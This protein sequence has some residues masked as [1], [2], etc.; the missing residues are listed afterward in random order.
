MLSKSLLL[1]KSKSMLIEYGDEEVFI[2]HRW[3]FKKD[4]RI[5]EENR[6]E[7]S[8]MVEEKCEVEEKNE[9]ELHTEDL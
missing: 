6:I 4:I 2:N 8:A 1:S 5:E 3:E 9:S 7:S